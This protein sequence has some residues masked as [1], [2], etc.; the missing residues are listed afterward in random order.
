VAYRQ[1]LA[2][3]MQET[4]LNSLISI[5]SLVQQEIVSNLPGL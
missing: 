2:N 1:P 3:S 4:V 5:V